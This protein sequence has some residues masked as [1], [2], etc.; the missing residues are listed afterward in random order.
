MLP[1]SGPGFAAQ[2]RVALLSLLISFL[3]KKIGSFI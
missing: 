1:R 2:P 3:G